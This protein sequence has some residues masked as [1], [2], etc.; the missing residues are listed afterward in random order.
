MNPAHIQDIIS[1]RST[2]VEPFSI[3]FRNKK[4]LLLDFKTHSGE[5]KARPF[6]DEKRHIL[7][8]SDGSTSRKDRYVVQI[9]GHKINTSSFPSPDLMVGEWSREAGVIII[10][11]RYRKKK[12]LWSVTTLEDANKLISE[13][14]S[15]SS[16]TVRAT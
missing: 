2:W 7:G 10:R 15:M 6:M 9:H 8:L 3:D 1:Q 12:L 4:T 16:R 11:A 5:E 14:F 13:P